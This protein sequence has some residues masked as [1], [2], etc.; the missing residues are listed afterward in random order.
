IVVVA[1]IQGFL[2]GLGFAVAGIESFAF[3][4]LMAAFVA[5]IP[6]IGTMLVWGPLVLLLWFKGAHFAAVGLFFWGG[7]VVSGIDN[8][9][10]P[11]FLQHGIKAP[12]FVLILAIICGMAVFGPIGLI[13]GPV[14][15]AIA[16]QLVEE[17]HKRYA[18]DAFSSD[19]T[20]N[21]QKQD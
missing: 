5:P 8:I 18:L 11:L 19:H 12:F 14:S 17:A 4:G 20:Q 10:R 6:M 7:I 1:L 15:L 9:F 21:D 3:W 2:C 13:A 16:I